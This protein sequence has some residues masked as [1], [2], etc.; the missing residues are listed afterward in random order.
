MTEEQSTENTDEKQVASNV[1]IQEAL[2]GFGD[3]EVEISALLGTAQ[4]PVEQFLK[5][6]RGAII[7]LS[8]KKDDDIDIHING[9][10]IGKADIT[11]IEENVAISVTEI[12]NRVKKI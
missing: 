9:F 10:P 11:I 6:G 12:N 7:E 3:I 8:R 4:M 5:L 2:E 1:T